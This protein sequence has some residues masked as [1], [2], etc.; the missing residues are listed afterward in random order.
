MD[1]GGEERERM[2]LKERMRKRET[3]RVRE[4]RWKK[5]IV[6]EREKLQEM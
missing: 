4:G 3:M 2:K 6:I 5:V 1:G